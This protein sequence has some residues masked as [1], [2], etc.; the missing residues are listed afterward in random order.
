MQAGPI[1]QFPVFIALFLAPVYVPLGLLHGWVHEV[2]RYN[3]L[4]RLVQ[5]GRSLLAG[6][7]TEVGAAY[8]VAATLI[9][10]FGLWAV[11]GLRSAEAAG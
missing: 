7:P 9:A 8:L 3:P 11:R 4:T 1:M 5:A 2:A 6:A 10:L